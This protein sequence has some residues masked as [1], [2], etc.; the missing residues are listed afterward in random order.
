M[1]RPQRVRFLLQALRER[2]YHAVVMSLAPDSAILDWHSGARRWLRAWGISFAVWTA[3]WAYLI[4]PDA[5]GFRGHLKPTS[6]WTLLPYL[7]DHWASAL[8][9]PI[10]L[11]VAWRFPLDRG[12]RWRSLPRLFLAMALFAAVDDAL[13]L[14]FR[15]AWLRAGI[16]EKL[17]SSPLFSIYVYTIFNYAQIVAVGWALHYQRAVRLREV[18]ASQL[19]ARLAQARL[20]A[21]RMQMHPHFLFNTLNAIA[22]LMHSDPAAAERMISRL[23]ELL[24]QSLANPTGQET[25][26]KQEL[27]L[28]ER[29][30]DIERVRFGE[31]LRVSVNAAPDTLDACV[32]SLILQ[33][34]V[35]NAIR[36]GIGS[37]IAGGSIALDVRREDAQL[38][39]QVADDGV[40]LSRTGPPG[41]S[42]GLGLR[43][44]RLRLE[45]LYGAAGQLSL[46]E[47]PGGGAVATLR[48]PFRAAILDTAVPEA[49]EP[50]SERSAARVPVSTP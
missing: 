31:R 29:Y 11:V 19:E 37:R 28:T 21:L 40:G 43:N 18:H 33:P 48:L 38:F 4:I 7:T 8:L 15:V 2:R 23:G 10:F 32:P 1:Q 41:Q 17:A 27:D 5:L 45:A 25:S 42:A 44:T 26:V 50:A 39:L 47:R 13:V 49:T 9:T 34:L 6:P 24:R 36:H 3:L 30:L 20:D 35:E 14:S 16:I 22:A 12:H 46:S